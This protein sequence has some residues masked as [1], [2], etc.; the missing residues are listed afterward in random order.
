MS[1]LSTWESIF[2]VLAMLAV[3][4]LFF[5]GAR[6]AI[7]ASKDAPKDWMAVIIPIAAVMAFV[8]I[9]IKLV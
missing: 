8:F 9:L 5:P 4:V 6:K 1:H 7:E 3:A 2:I